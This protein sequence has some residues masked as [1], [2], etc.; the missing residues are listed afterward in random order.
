MAAYMIGLL[1]VKDWD[2]YREYRAVAEPLVA[3]HG[4]KYLVKGGSPTRLEGDAS[5]P[6][7]VV[8]LE[9]PTRE[10]LNRFYADPDYL[11]VMRLR[12]STV[13]AELWVVDSVGM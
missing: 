4:G 5:V 8:M 7:A 3:K 12:Q 11:P 2:W 9:F 10:H 1:R 13:A 6:D